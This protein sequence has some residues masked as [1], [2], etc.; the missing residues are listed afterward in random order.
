MKR[1]VLMFILIIFQI[2]AQNTS[3][4]FTMDNGLPQNSIKDIVKDKYGFIWLS[5][6]NGIVR[7]DGAGFQ[8]YSK[9]PIDNFHFG[10]FYG[11][12]H[13]DSIILYNDYEE[14]K[15]LINKRT[16]KIIQK[17]YPDYTGKVF[18]WSGRILERPKNKKIEAELQYLIKTGNDKYHIYREKVFY[19]DKKGEKKRICTLPKASRYNIFISNN[20]LFIIDSKNRE[21]RRIFRES[22]ITDKTPTLFNDPNTKIYWYQ[23]TDQTFII[24]NDDI[25][26]VSYHKN[27]LKLHFVTRY[28]NFANYRFG[29]MYY[30]AKYNRLYL[31]S[32]IK[33]LNIVQL[34]QFHTARKNLPYVD[35]VSYASLP[36]SDNTI[37][38][39]LGYQYTKYGAIKEHKFGSNEKYYMLYDNDGNIMY[40]RKNMIFKRH[41]SSG[42]VTADSILF[43]GK[44]SNGVFRSFGLYGISETDFINSS[45]HLFSDSNLKK[46]AFSF[47]YQGIINNFIKYNN[48]DLLVGSTHGLYLTSLD[49]RKTVLIKRFNVK[50]IVKTRDGNIWITTNKEGIFLLKQK[51]LFKIPL[52]EQHYLESAH[53]ILDDPFGYYWISSNN[54]LFKVSRQQ[55]LRSFENNNSPVIYYRFTKKDGLLTN[56][57]NGGSVPNAHLLPN[58]EM[59]FPSM[60]G[61][62][63]FDP[64]KARTYYPEKNTI[65][66]ER[67][68]IGREDIT[69]FHQH[70]NLENDYKSA[71]IFIDLPYYADSSNLKI[72]AKIDYQDR[73]WEKIEAGNQR[74][75]T[76][77]NLGPGKY[78]LHI[79]VLISPNGEYQYQTV[80]FEIK[81]LFYQTRF[82]KIVLFLFLSLIVILIILNTTKFIR[83]MNKVLKKKVSN[84]S[85]ELQETSQDLENAKKSIQKESEYQNKF[86]EAVNHDLTT[87]IRFIAMLAEKLNEEKDSEVQKE[88]FEGI[89]QTSEEL[90]KFTLTLKEYNKLYATN[91][92]FEETGF[93]L[94]EIFESKQ[95]LFDII[96]KKKNNQIEIR[97]QNDILCF[98]N[99]GIIACIIHNI[100]DNAVK[101]SNDSIITLFAKQ[102]GE[103]ISLQIADTGNGMTDEQLLYYNAIYRNTDDKK[104]PFKDFGFGLHMVIQLIKKINAEIKFTKNTPT[105]TIVEISLKNKN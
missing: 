62:V 8:T 34:T 48:H 21:T 41:K 10:G 63:F 19:T 57:F 104:T 86:L 102:N 7:Y 103:R 17:K 16:P 97:S 66:I 38:D 5:T 2:Q 59:V 6:D 88:Y 77:R 94:N 101:Y 90:Y 18:Y 22:V 53:D 51:K 42:Y 31:G 50:N 12:I 64:A 65:F 89:H 30:D 72:E 55:L 44:T 91:I 45:L 46:A 78:T 100:I 81:P 60:E 95:R 13:S 47:K 9:L 52:D 87:P 71:D 82:F 24:H 85:Q 39:A 70:I 4:W 98:I 92:V 11:N 58:K 83:K 33:G 76:L 93:S 68:K 15:I 20:T 80:T 56:E 73:K 23:L 69:P 36:F 40:K 35:D 75:Y 25:Y 27:E 105:G 28:E 29:C 79:R 67:M 3:S 61:F 49:T 84:M 43:K 1:W 26:L 32:S 14:N 99:K 96:A 37:I 54:G 74:K